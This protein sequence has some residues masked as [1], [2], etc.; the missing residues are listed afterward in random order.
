MDETALAQQRMK[1]VSNRGNAMYRIAAASLWMAVLATGCGEVTRPDDTS[2]ASPD[3][4]DDAAGRP[5]DADVN[6]V[7]AQEPA[8]DA[9]PSPSWSWGTYAL[10][11]QCVEGCI[12]DSPL[13]YQDRATVG[14][15]FM[16]WRSTCGT[17]A[18]CAPLTGV[19]SLAD[20]CPTVEGFDN[21]DSATVNTFTVCMNGGAIAGDVVYRGY[22]GPADMTR[23]W[24]FEGQPL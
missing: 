4:P 16:F 23:R 11:W 2:D 8:G 19:G 18:E 14:D 12:T 5:I 6:P 22:P 7:D 13:Q 1:R 21:W 15:L 3:T 9:E 24:H 10:T 17:S 20:P